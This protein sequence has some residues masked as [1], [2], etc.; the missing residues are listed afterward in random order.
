MSKEDAIC[1]KCKEGY[2]SVLSSIYESK[3]SSVSPN[4]DIFSYDALDNNSSVSC[5]KPKLINN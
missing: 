2:Y 1:I 3:F 5:V 4:I